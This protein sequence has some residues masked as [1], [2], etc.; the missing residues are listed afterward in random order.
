MNTRFIDYPATIGGE[1]TISPVGHW[2]AQ[3]QYGESLSPH[4]A[5]VG[6][7]GALPEAIIRRLPK[8]LARS[9][10]VLVFIRVF[11]RRFFPLGQSVIWA[12]RRSGPFSGEQHIYPRSDLPKGFFGDFRERFEPLIES[13]E[14]FPGIFP[15]LP[16]ILG[17]RL[18]HWALQIHKSSPFRYAW[19]LF[20]PGRFTALADQ[21]RGTGLRPASLSCCLMDIFYGSP[22]RPSSWDWRSRSRIRTGSRPALA[23]SFSKGCASER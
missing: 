20:A 22:S 5:K 16:G 2:G 17:R 1:Q 10:C 18:F 21:R 14:L 19:C 12:R 9:I 3:M 4:S 8:S 15:N 6:M 13:I 11:P 7:A 23:A